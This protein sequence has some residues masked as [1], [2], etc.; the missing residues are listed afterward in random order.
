MT[1]KISS[2]SSKKRCMAKCVSKERK[3][4]RCKRR[5]S[6]GKSYCEIHEKYNSRRVRFSDPIIAIGNDDIAKMRDAETQTDES[7]DD[8]PELLI[9]SSEEELWI[10]SIPSYIA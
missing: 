9:A 5:I 6:S 3:N 8:Y 2:E 4:L 1:R 10:D 7:D